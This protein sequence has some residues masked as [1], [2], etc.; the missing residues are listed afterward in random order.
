MTNASPKPFRLFLSHAAIDAGMALVLA[1][2]IRAR[3]GLEVFVSSQPGQIQT[4]DKWMQAIESKLQTGDTYLVLLTPRS[5]ERPWVWFEVGSVWFR[6]RRILPV[7][8]GGLSPGDVPYPLASRQIR[9]MA[10]AADVQQ[11]FRD[12][13]IELA[14]ADAEN[15]TGN[16]R[17]GTATVD[18]WK[19]LRFED[20]VLVW[21]G[22]LSRLPD[23]SSI[24]ATRALVA[25]LEANGLQLRCGSGPLVPK[26]YDKGFRQ[27][28][29][30]DLSNWKR[31]V[32]CPDYPEHFLLCR[33]REE[34][35]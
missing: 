32:M 35:Q 10:S 28:Y 22:P 25:F 14:T 23:W 29:E 12:L 31:L 5:I 19:S 24:V 9:D 21:D 27:V 4:G 6:E 34:A 3:S 33:P 15:L 20:R 2:E 26:H 7:T 1:D 8:G 30:S 18:T 16:L 13:D 11:L 17:Q